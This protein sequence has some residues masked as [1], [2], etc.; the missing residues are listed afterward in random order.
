MRQKVVLHH[1]KNSGLPIHPSRSIG[2]C[3]KLNFEDL[4]QSWKPL[5]IG[6]AEFTE[7]SSRSE[8]L[9]LLWNLI[10]LKKIPRIYLIL[11]SKIYEN[12]CPAEKE[13]EISDIPQNVFDE[14]ILNLREI[15]MLGWICC[16]CQRESPHQYYKAIRPLTNIVLY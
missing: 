4:G 15:R 8:I 14:G 12:K 2:I 13:V 9:G 10:Q 1:H 7:K 11:L 6:Q 3:I 16:F 5:K